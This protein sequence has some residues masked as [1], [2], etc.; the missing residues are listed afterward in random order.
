MH[1][2]QLQYGLWLHFQVER[3]PCSDG[4]ACTV[5]DKC[6]ASACQPGQAVKCNDGNPCTI[7]S[8]NPTSGQCEAKPQSAGC[9]DG[10]A[11]TE[12]DNCAQGQCKGSAKL[13]SDGNECTDD[14]CNP[15]SGC[16]FS[17][18]AKLC[19]NGDA[20]SINDQCQ[21]GGCKAGTA[22][23]CSDGNPCTADSCN[24]SN[25]QCAFANNA[26]ACDDGNGCTLSDSC[27]GGSCIPGVTKNCNDGNPCTDDSCS[28]G[29]GKCDN[30][31]NGASCNDGDACTSGDGCSG[32][33]C[34]GVAKDCTG[35][36]DQCSVGS[37]S[38]GS[39]VK[40][41]KG[42]GTPC[43]DGN[44]CTISDACNGGVC[45]GNKP[46]ETCNGVDDDCDGIIDNMPSGTSGCFTW[47]QRYK[48]C[49]SRN[50]LA[51]WQTSTTSQEASAGAC[52]PNPAAPTAG[53]GSC[54]LSTS[55]CS[56]PPYAGYDYLSCWKSVSGSAGQFRT[57]SQ[58]KPSV[59]VTTLM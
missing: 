42:S 53:C 15:A 17:N 11:C 41:S 32:G 21:A 20:C 44:N 51:G 37:C 4:P 45:K 49:Q 39:C 1:F 46:T 52:P 34:K 7:D 35:L 59:G 54:S 27:S 24:I 25:G 56:I 48:N 31:A 43:N 16:A 50:W 14:G 12:N 30:V 47:V 10:S 58:S 22:K 40:V 9:D 29:S 57:Y 33:S 6:S 2:G 23:I 3:G 38:S 19:N 5:D 36:F 28:G 18:N 55:I 13:C 8:Y 26:G